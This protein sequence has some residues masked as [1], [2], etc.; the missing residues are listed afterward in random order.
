[1][2]LALDPLDAAQPLVGRRARTRTAAEP[3]VGSAK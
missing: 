3:T 1:M 2:P